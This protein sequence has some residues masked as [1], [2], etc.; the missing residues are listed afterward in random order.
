MNSNEYMSKNASSPFSFRINSEEK[1]IFQSLYPY[2]MSRFIKRCISIA[3][4]D[5]H[6]FNQVYFGGETNE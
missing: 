4:K 2:C 6:F 3:I 1:Q 5:K